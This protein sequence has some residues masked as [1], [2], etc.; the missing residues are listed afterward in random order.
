MSSRIVIPV[1]FVIACGGTVGPVDAGPDG[2]ADAPAL[3]QDAPADAPD[4]PDAPADA[5]AACPVLGVPC[6]PPTGPTWCAD[7]GR[8]WVCDVGVWELRPCQPSDA[9]CSGS[10]CS[11]VK[12]PR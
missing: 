7:D 9:L 4:A 2:P 12:C 5:P 6:G 1:I 11:G 10:V 3:A 8:V